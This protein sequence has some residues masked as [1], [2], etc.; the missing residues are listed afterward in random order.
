MPK[1]A[2]LMPDPS[3]ITSIPG[4]TWVTWEPCTV[5]PVTSS[6]PTANKAPPNTIIHLIDPGDQ[7]AGRADPQADHHTEGEVGQSGLDGRPVQHLLPPRWICHG[8]S[9]TEPHEGVKLI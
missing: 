1:L 7:G 9:R 2:M 6:M 4:R 8:S 5:M 3:A